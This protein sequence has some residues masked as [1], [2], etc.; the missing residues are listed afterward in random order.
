[1]EFFTSAEQEEEFD[2][3][4][5]TDIE[6][7]QKEIDDIQKK[8]KKIQKFT[9]YA[10]ISEPERVFIVSDEGVYMNNQ[11]CPKEL[12]P[13]GKKYCFDRDFKEKIEKFLEGKTKYMVKFYPSGRYG[14]T[15]GYCARKNEMPSK[16]ILDTGLTLDVEDQD[17]YDILCA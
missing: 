14:P 15:I 1:M 3:I 12:V 5:K 9:A 8:T 11:L 13:G 10:H 4:Y 2:K 16:I 7:K 6:I 17:K